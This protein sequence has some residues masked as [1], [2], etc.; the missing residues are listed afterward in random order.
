M[1]DRKDAPPSLHGTGETIIAPGTQIQGDLRSTS[2]VRLDGTLQ[3]NI[4]VEGNVYIGEAGRVIGD[5]SAGS[6]IVEG[7][8]TGNIESAGKVHL[9][10]AAKLRG[11]IRSRGLSVQDGAWFEG[12]ISDVKAETEPLQEPM[13]QYQEAPVHH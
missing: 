1:H 5:I 10:A 7:D 12:R 3:G 13:T 9:G 11:N 2:N 6:I 8:V 4:I